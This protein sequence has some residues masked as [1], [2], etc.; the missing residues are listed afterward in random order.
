MSSSKGREITRRIKQIEHGRGPI[1]R[2]F[3]AQAEAYIAQA[4]QILNWHENTNQSRPARLR[5]LYHHNRIV[6]FLEKASD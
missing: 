6:K 2:L 3:L 4:S 1:T 5:T